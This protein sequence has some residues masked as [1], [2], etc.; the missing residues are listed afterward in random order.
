MVTGGGH[1]KL[2]ETMGIIGVPVMSK[3]SFISTERDI[4]EWW[5]QELQKSMIEAGKEERELAMSRGDYHEGVPAITVIVDGGWSKRPHKHSYNAN[6]GV[7]IIIGKATCK[8]DVR[9][10]YCSVCAR[11]IPPDKHH[12]YRN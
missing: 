5:Q 9:E 12:C 6:S 11:N 1:R 2:D 8:L 10:K 3:T 4:G 7:G